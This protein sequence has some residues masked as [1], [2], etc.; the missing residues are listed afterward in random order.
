MFQRRKATETSLW[1]RHTISQGNA[2]GE[3]GA[4]YAG[5]QLIKT[6]PKTRRKQNNDEEKREQQQGNP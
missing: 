1:Q 6:N 2:S 4:S 3:I 5:A